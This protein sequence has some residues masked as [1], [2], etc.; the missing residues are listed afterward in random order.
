MHEPYGE[1]TLIASNVNLKGEFE[2][3]TNT[4]S[5]LFFGLLFSW[6]QVEALNCEAVLA[7]AGKNIEITKS[8]GAAVATHYFNH[9][10]KKEKDLTEGEMAQAEVEIFGSGKGGGEYSRTK[11]EQDL[12]HWCTTNKNYAESHEELYRASQT[13]HAESVRAWASC[14]ALATQDSVFM[15]PLIADNR[16]VQMSIRYTG[17]AHGGV[18]FYGI[19]PVGFDCKVQYPEKV[20]L[21][22]QPEKVVLGDQPTNTNIYSALP[23]SEVIEAKGIYIGPEAIS[24]NCEREAI[25]KE[26]GGDKYTFLPRGV[27]SMGTGQHPFQLGFAEQRIPPL[28]QQTLEQLKG[29][30]DELRKRITEV[31]TNVDARFSALETGFQNTVQAMQRTVSTLDQQAVRFNQYLEVRWDYGVN[32]CLQAEGGQLAGWPRCDP[33]QGHQKLIFR[34]R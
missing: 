24:V 18:K 13:I 19:T 10:T 1:R 4:R 27:I 34:P 7:L 12:L 2:M 14:N 22:D 28:A 8:S 9:C 33:N 29:E 15:N 32:Y 25:S 16:T 23:S 20:V 31:H 30:L 21:G 11:R 26:E 3:N 5:A 17:G 6:S